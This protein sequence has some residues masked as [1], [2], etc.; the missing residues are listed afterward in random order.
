MGEADLRLTLF[1]P[2]VGK[3]HAVARSAA[4]PGSKTGG[5]LDLLTRCSLLLAQ[6]RYGG[7]DVVAQAHTIHSFLPLR[8]SLEGIG[9]GLYMAELVDRFLPERLEQPQ[10]YYLMLHALHR[11]AQGDSE[12]A[13]RHF[14]VQILVA[15]GYSPE[16]YHC[17]GCQADME[18]LPGFFSPARGGLVCPRCGS[19][20]AVTRALSAPGVQALRRLAG[21]DLGAVPKLSPEVCDELRGLLRSY[22]TYLLERDVASAQ[23]LDSI[24]RV[25]AEPS[26]GKLRTWP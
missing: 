4:K 24:R 16:L 6:P 21:A 10:V 15:L 23:F 26:S 11:L 7:M 12:S 14:E 25:P 9:Q 3:V 13:V 17:L 22:I 19:Q 8:Q 2:T 20:E 1:T 18:R 5:H